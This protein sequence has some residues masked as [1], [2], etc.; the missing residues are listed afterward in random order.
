MCVLNRVRLFATPWTVAHQAP[1]SMGFPRKES[2]SGLTFP[3]PR[4]IQTPALADRFLYTSQSQSPNSFHSGIQFS[5]LH[6]TSVV[7][8][9]CNCASMTSHSLVSTHP[10]DLLWPS[11]HHCQCQQP[12]LGLVLSNKPQQSAL[13]TSFL[14][15]VCPPC[16]QA[17]CPSGSLLTAPLVLFLSLFHP[18]PHR[19][20]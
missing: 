18:L 16:Y 11:F 14:L 9:N 8:L 12:L 10:I 2:W 7:S 5:S 19:H 3:T 15:L 13:W 17:S 4:D 20:I 1:L 6:S